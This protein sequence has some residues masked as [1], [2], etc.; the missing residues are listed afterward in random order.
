MIPSVQLP[1]YGKRILVTAPRN[2]AA[3]LISQLINQGA[4][5]VL[6]PTIET[7]ALADFTELD[8]T[9]MQIDTF[10]WIAFTSRNGIDAFFKR[11]EALEISVSV[12][13]NCRIS[14]IGKDAERLSDFGIK[15]DLIPQE[16]SPKGIIA[17]LAKVPNINK[18]TVLVPVPEVVGIAEPNVIPEFVAGLKKLGMSVTRVP[19]YTTRCLDKSLYE[20]ELHLIRQGKIDAIAFSSTA[21]ISGFLQMVTSKADYQQCVIACF[22]PYTAANARKLGL[23]VSIVAEN[24]SSFAGFAEAIANFM[25]LLSSK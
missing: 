21:E 11:L 24:Y 17:E 22:G 3:R 23:N 5:P 18:Q 16:P 6:M 25:L 8:T 4:L 1:L 15:V 10:D 2:Y 7:C 9:L 12:L 20:V 19:T 14:A 13:K